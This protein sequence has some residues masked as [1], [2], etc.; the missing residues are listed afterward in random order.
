MIHKKILVGGA[1]EVLFGIFLTD[2][3]KSASWSTPCHLCNLDLRL[4]HDISPNKKSFLLRSSWGNEVKIV[5]FGTFLCDFD[6]WFQNCLLE[7]RISFFQLWA[8]TPWWCS[9][10]Q[11]IHF[12]KV[13]LGSRT[14]ECIFQ[15]FLTG[16]SKTASWKTLYLFLISDLRL[17]LDVPRNKNS[18]FL[19]SS[20]GNETIF[21]KRLGFF[22]KFFD[23]GRKN[24]IPLKMYIYGVVTLDRKKWNRKK[25]FIIQA[26]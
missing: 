26:I 23:F 16:D 6:W 9:S 21:K 19:K 4:L 5:L 3:S 7:H 14:P 17:F 10:Q 2:G 12:L 22:L 15:V 25:I 13:L 8:K 24:K 18:I 20:L 11:K 1:L